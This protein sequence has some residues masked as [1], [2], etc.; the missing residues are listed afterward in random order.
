MGIL[1]W[2][3]GGTARRDKSGSLSLQKAQAIVNAYGAALASKRSGVVDASQLPH[4]KSR[5]KAALVVVMQ[6]TPEGSMRN[7][8]KAGYVSLADWQDGT[9]KGGQL[10]DATEIQKR[11]APEAAQLAGELKS[12]GL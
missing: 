2:L 6:A 7:L 5:I 3:S 8:L 10:V 9:G 1:N 11:V 4:P 12:L